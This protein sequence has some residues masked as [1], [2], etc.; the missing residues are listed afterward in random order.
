MATARKD[1]LESRQRVLAAELRDVNSHLLILLSLPEH[2][3]PYAAVR[4]KIDNLIRQWPP[5]E[6]SAE[7]D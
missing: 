6:T 7:D 4:K 5:T 1:F 2:E 3:R